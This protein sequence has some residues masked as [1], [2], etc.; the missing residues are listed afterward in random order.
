MINKLNN[1]LKKG[2]LTLKSLNKNI[3][4]SENDKRNLEKMN[5][6]K[7]EGELK[8]KAKI[9]LMKMVEE[10]NND[11]YLQKYLIQNNP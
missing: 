6:I 7:K 8:I 5:Q 2:S 3:N 11:V 1:K 4:N 10:L 9:K